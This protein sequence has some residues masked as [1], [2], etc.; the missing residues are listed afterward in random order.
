MIISILNWKGGVGKTTTA[1][2]VAHILADMGYRILAVDLDG[3]SNLTKAIVNPKG[4]DKFLPQVFLD[5]DED[6]PIYSTR[7]A[8]LDLVPN[9]RQ[10]M[11]RGAKAL[12]IE[13]DGVY[14]LKNKLNE[15]LEDYDH[16]IMDCPPEFS[17]VTQ[18][19]M[20]AS[21]RLII[22][23]ELDT[24]AIEGILDITKEIEV[25]HKKEMNPDLRISGVI[26]YKPKLRTNYQSAARELLSEVFNGHIY[27]TIVRENIYVAEARNQK[28]PITEYNPMATGAID[29]TNLVDEIVVHEKMSK[30]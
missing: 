22:P 7:K 4:L 15:V 5:E 17:I 8:N 19:A 24:D 23:T 2:N 29:F 6:L 13:V 26:I 11:V 30:P 27:R 12:V 16:I 25:I 3:Q 20:I 28:M 9:N 18:N 1:L 21:D 10:K 14:R